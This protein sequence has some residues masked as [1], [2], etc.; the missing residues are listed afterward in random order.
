MIGIRSAI[1]IRARGQRP[2][3]EAVYMTAPRSVCRTTKK[4][5]AERAR[6]IHDG[7]SP[8]IAPSAEQ[9]DDKPATDD[10]Q[11]GSERHFQHALRHRMRGFYA[12]RCGQ[13]VGGL[14]RH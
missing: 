3:S 8:L 6:S 9:A 10:E 11:I 14:A 4:A 7:V 1:S 5:L 12:E 13:Q 2:H